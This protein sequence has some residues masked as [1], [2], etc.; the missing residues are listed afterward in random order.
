MI[1]QGALVYTKIKR[2]DYSKPI[3]DI[4]GRLNSLRSSYLRSGI[5]V[6][7]AWW[8]MWVPVA[9][10]IGFDIVLHPNSLVGSLV[11]G[12][13]GFLV[14]LWLYWRLLKSDSGSGENWKRKLSGESIRSAYM[15]LD[16][17]E[18]AQIR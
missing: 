15:A 10:A 11:V 3:A 9:V 4:R 2:I 18:M 13:I 5:I 14:S 6:G 7:F 12:V 17:I 1:S 8:L 16:E